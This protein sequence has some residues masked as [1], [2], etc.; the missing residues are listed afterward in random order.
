MIPLNTV[1]GSAGSATFSKC[2]AYRYILERGPVGDYINFIMLNPSTATHEQNDPTIRRCISYAL[3]NGFLALRIT[4]IFALRATNPKEL[5]KH[6]DPVG[7]WNDSAIRSVAEKAKMI[8]CGWGNH[9]N[10]INDRADHV[11]NL[12]DGLPLHVLKVTKNG[13]PGHPLYLKRDIKPFRWK[14]DSRGG[15]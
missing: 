8:V 6:S 5:Y 9:G 2:D 12:L 7:P 15:L 14:G 11:V 10:A 13:D 4:N 1:Y 3:D